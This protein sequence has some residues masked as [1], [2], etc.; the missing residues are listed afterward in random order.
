MY[1]TGLQMFV[2]MA[3]I[4]GNTVVYGVQAL[5][6]VIYIKERVFQFNELIRNPFMA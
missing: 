2:C 3:I 6:C 4:E 5:V 1:N